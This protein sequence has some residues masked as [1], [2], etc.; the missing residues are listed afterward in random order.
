M[1]DDKNVWS[2]DDY[3][4]LITDQLKTRMDAE[5]ATM[6]QAYVDNSTLDLFADTI[7]E[8]A[9]VQNGLMFSSATFSKE[10][11]ETVSVD[12]IKSELLGEMLSQIK[13]KIGRAHV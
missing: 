8:S 13:K 7:M 2:Y 4:D 9:L 11:N 12:K 10:I 5:M 3:A 6:T 1:G